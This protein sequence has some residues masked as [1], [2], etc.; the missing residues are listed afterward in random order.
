MGLFRR[1][2]K[3]PVDGTLQVVSTTGRPYRGVF[4]VCRMRVVVQAPGIE[5]FATEHNAGLVRGTQWP[6]TGSVLAAR[7]DR[8]D[9][10][11]FEI[12]WDEV[13]TR[14]QLA[15]D[16]AEAIAAAMG[17]RRPTDQRYRPVYRPKRLT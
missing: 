7:I 9:P 6:V 13:P 14:E 1:R 17:A 10:E 15:E 12:L 11:R 16:Q 5:A 2:M 8:A 4:G 3:D